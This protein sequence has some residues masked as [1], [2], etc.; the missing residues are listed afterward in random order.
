M[1]PAPRPVEQLAS[2]PTCAAA[3]PDGLAVG[4]VRGEAGMLADALVY[5]ARGL[6]DRVFAV[7]QAAVVVDQ[8]GCLFTPPVVG[9]R[10]GQPLEFVNS[11][12]TLHNVHGAPTASAAWNFGLG[13]QGARRSIV[14]DRAEV[15]VPVRCDVHPW[16]RADVGVFAHPYF[17][18]T[19]ADGAFVFPQV[20]AGHYVVGTWHP[21][22]G[23]REQPV[24]LAPG[25][26]AVADVRFTTD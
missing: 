20:P 25:G 9:V 13:V 1:P 16:M 11:D 2:D 3:H 23:R 8:R 5:V 22:L 12:D 21:L 26:T 7:P 10:A 4:S 6:E 19:G 14:I 18:V 24:D 15:P 17:A